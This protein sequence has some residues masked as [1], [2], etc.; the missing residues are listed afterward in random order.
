MIL[1]FLIPL[2][3]SANLGYFEDY[4]TI[5]N[6]LY[7]AP[8]QSHSYLY[9][10]PYEQLEYGKQMITD[11]IANITSSQKS[12][13]DVQDA[14]TSAILEAYEFKQVDQYICENMIKKHEITECY[15]S[16]GLKSGDDYCNDQWGKDG[17]L[18]EIFREIC[19]EEYLQK[20]RNLNSFASKKY[21][22][23]VQKY[24]KNLE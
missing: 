19:G 21:D 11:C 6:C 2:V 1:L 9:P 15:K 13:E 10:L 8:K 7:D 23:C 14:L 22:D 18:I 3:F 24:F 12:L 20:M 5:H 16:S 17:C 4:P